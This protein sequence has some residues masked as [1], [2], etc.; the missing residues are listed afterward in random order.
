MRVP[1]RAALSGITAA[2]GALAATASLAADGW[3]PVASMP[4]AKHHA[5]AVNV[6]G[7]LYVVGGPPWTP[8]DLDGTAYR[9]S[10]GTWST[11]APIDGEG[12]VLGLGGGI[13]GLGRIV[14]FGGVNSDNGDVAAS[15]VYDPVQGAAASLADRSDLAPLQHFAVAR[16]DLGRLYS[17]GGGVGAQGSNS[18][19]V[20]RYHA[21]TNTWQ[22]VASMPVAV[23][24][25]CAADDGAGHIL[26]FG[27]FN[28]NGTA[29]SANVWRLDVATN[30]WSD[31]AVPDLPVALSHAKAV[32]GNDHRI[33][34]I[35]GEGGA[36]PGGTVLSSVYV[37]NLIDNTWSSAPPMATPRRDAAAVLGNDDFVYV[38]GGTTAGG[39][40]V[41]TVERLFAPTCPTFLVQSP[42]SQAW[43]G[44]TISLSASVGGGTP[45]TFQWTHD[46]VLLADGPTGSGSSV[47]GSATPNLAIAHVGAADIGDYRLVAG[48]ACGSV[49]SPAI[50]LSLRV[51][52]PI[53]AHWTVTNLH[54]A[55]AES[56][57]G[58]CVGG[59]RQGGFAVMDVAGYNNLEQPVLWAGSAASAVN[60]TPAGSVGGAVYDL[61]GD[62]AVGSWWWP[63]SCSS[64]GQWY[65]C[66]YWQACR[67]VGMD[68]TQLAHDPLQTSGWEVGNATCIKDDVI[69]G[70][71]LLEAGQPGG[72]A[73]VWTPPGYAT[74][75]MTPVN[76]SASWISALDG[77]DA[78]GGI[79]T[80]LPGSTN[81]AARFPGGSASDWMDLHPAGYEAS[82][83]SGA[84]AGQQVGTTGW[85]NDNH[86]A[87]WYGTASSHL[88]LHPAWATRSGLSA[89]MGGVQSGFAT[90][91]GWDH[92]TLWNGSA[93]SAVDL[94]GVLSADY[95]VSEAADLEVRA[96]GSIVVVGSA[97]NA[98]AG[99]WE[100]MLWTSG[101]DALLGDLDG[102]GDV[103]GADLAVLLGA[104]GTS[105]P[106]ADLDD[107]GVV[108][109]ADLAILL[110]AW[111]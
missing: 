6:A 58:T 48:N 7:T 97:Y 59:D 95:T 49:S 52:P 5:I 15:K 25:A 84:D 12:P 93:A 73:I 35:G 79:Q 69:G 100:A 57:T 92:A 8:S 101:P 86:A 33:Y 72:H 10:G 67:W 28:A 88:D 19:F 85:F 32:R 110:G 55:W 75:P 47:S 3:Q 46:G 45:M 29:R 103:D 106:A 22:A 54:P 81:H 89:C 36:V 98:V 24:D 42:A 77:G 96:D 61:E 31:T 82:G 16:D 11:V 40:A 34:V 20:E 87:L 1:L 4:G 37:L 105:N 83:I 102:D 39:G 53:P 71:Q 91:G 9:L 74:W 21:A 64:G 111:G 51:P 104:W 108:A 38:F 17:I 13:D 41:S 65:S 66:Y 2:C 62:V 18:S 80:P 94:H 78:F 109:G 27:G 76:T 107:D 68:A 60:I 63:Y 50:A 44:Q 43:E 70:S 26:V 56:S 23:A 30:A 90:V 14:L 99:R